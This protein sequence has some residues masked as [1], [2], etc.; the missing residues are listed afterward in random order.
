M[1]RLLLLI[2][3]IFSLS[4][5]SIT[6][7]GVYFSDYEQNSSNYLL[8]HYPLNKF[9]DL[10]LG[11]TYILR[12]IDCRN[13]GYSDVLSCLNPYWTKF[14]YLRIKEFSVYEYPVDKNITEPYYVSTNQLGMS[15]FQY[16]FLWAL[17]G[18]FSGFTFLVFF[19]LFVSG[20]RS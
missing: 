19:I 5:A 6:L 17:T 3:F 9:S 11:S 12:I 13:G 8:A 4:N 1:I 15:D 7:Q 14:S 16:N 2:T 10:N 20:K 18:I